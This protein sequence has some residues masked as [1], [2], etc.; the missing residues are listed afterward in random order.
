[1]T[2]TPRL[3]EARAKV[4]KRVSLPE[5]RDIPYISKREGFPRLYKIIANKV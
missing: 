1:M 2:L 5:K 4:L 3:K